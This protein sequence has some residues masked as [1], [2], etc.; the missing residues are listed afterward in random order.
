MKEKMKL[1]I[2]GPEERKWPTE[3]Q[4][5][6]AKDAITKLLL[7]TPNL[8]TTQLAINFI[9]HKLKDEIIEATNAL[10]SL[11][12]Y[13]AK[14]IKEVTL[15]SGHCPVGKERPY[16]VYCG[17]FLKEWKEDV[18]FHKKNHK[19]IYVYDKGGVDTWAEIIATEL[20]IQKEIH[21]ADCTFFDNMIPKPKRMTYEEC[22][23]VSHPERMAK[24]HF[25]KYHFKPRNIDMAKAGDVGYCIVPRTYIPSK[26]EIQQGILADYDEGIYCKHCNELGHPSNGGCFT[27]KEMRKL[28]KET[29]VVV[30]D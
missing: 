30:I 4:K 26:E 9:Q 1:V 18:E 16:C 12:D 24:D 7:G 29:H 22:K 17:R 10:G 6:K 23:N 2:V 25:W 15:V 19:V 8:K 11:D 20:G 28:G 13:V 21:P 27:I 3:E 14:R 5:E